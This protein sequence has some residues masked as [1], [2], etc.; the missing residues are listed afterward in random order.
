MTLL[1]MDKI[2]VHS[3]IIRRIKRVALIREPSY[4][5]VS[6]DMSGVK[7]I[8]ILLV[9]YRYGTQTIRRWIS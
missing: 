6:D 5:I 9:M 7:S 3:I 1:P 8:S 4:L 2:Y